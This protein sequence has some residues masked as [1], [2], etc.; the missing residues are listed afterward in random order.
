MSFKRSETYHQLV[1]KAYWSHQHRRSVFHIEEEDIALARLYVYGYRTQTIGA[2]HAC[3]EAVE[4][5]LESE[6]NDSEALA[7]SLRLL[8]ELGALSILPVPADFRVLLFTLYFYDLKIQETI[9]SLDSYRAA[10][11]SPA[12]QT[13]MDRFIANIEQ[14][15]L[16]NGVSIAQDNVVPE[17]GT[18]QVPKLG[19]TLVPLVYGDHHS[20]SSAYVTSDAEGKTTHRHRRGVEIH[21]GFS[22]IHGRTIMG[23]CCTEL[24]EGYAMPIPAMTDHGFDNLSEHKHL[25]PFVFGS[26]T[27]GGWGVFFDVEPRPKD[28]G[29]LREV[30]LASSSMNKSVYLE[31]EISR[32]ESMQGS[33]RE[34]LIPS[35]LT[36]SPGTAGLEMGLGKVE[37]GGLS[38]T[39]DRF[40]IVSVRRGAAE[41]RVGPACAE[42]QAHDHVGIP[43]GMEA[44]ISS[45]QGE[46]VLFLDAFLVSD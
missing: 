9:A 13:I 28:L 25:V 4:R 39:D 24:H 14:V 19:F 29:H 36:A 40:R 33:C 27:L 42:L 34:I 38:L 18:F 41:I 35:T 6:G 12:V 22:P 31:R 11:R 7:R 32:V 23:D 37:A 2:F 16:G 45:K 1:E 8:D 30:P 17:Q 10:N 43:G 44:Q 15:P 3:H 26:A 21:L 20:W 46:P 5:I